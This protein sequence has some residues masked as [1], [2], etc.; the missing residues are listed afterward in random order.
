[1]CVCAGVYYELY[2]CN[3]GAKRGPLSDRTTS[4]CYEK[5]NVDGEGR[6]PHLQLFNGCCFFYLSSITTVSRVL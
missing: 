5:H 4:V 6:R 2:E 3:K 1:M